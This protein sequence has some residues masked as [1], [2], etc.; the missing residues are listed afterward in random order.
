MNLTEAREEIHQWLLDEG[1]TDLA[2][3]WKEVGDMMQGG[4]SAEE[5][6]LIL[7][8]RKHKA[9]SKALADAIGL[10]KGNDA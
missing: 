4:L 5:V 9:F 7:Q 6:L 1:E 10:M 2:E 3:A 8:R